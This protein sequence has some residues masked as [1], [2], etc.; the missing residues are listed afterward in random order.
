MLDKQALWDCCKYGI[1]KGPLLLPSVLAAVLVI[2][3]FCFVS[4][5][6]VFWFHDAW[7]PLL[8]AISLPLIDI[9]AAILIGGMLT[10]FYVMA[11]KVVDG[12]PTGLQDL[13]GYFNR[14]FYHL[15][16]F[17]AIYLGLVS[18]GLIA[19][20]IPGIYVG[21]RLS[22]T[23]YVIA[24]ADLTLWDAMRRSWAITEGRCCK[25]VVFWLGVNSLRILVTAL[26]FFLCFEFPSQWIVLGFYE[27]FALIGWP[28]SMPIATIAYA[29]LYRKLSLKF[30]RLSR[31]VRLKV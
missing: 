12:Q 25:L 15:L 29:S 5:F 4:L 31:I 10:A 3:S 22:V 30:P 14:K 11:L 17:W 16:G 1:R 24:D 7:S 21:L 28:L 9:S 27:Q 26:I 8:R 2:C 19:A 23:P 13:F 6:S 18:L 20:V